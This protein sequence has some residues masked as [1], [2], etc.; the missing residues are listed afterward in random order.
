MIHLRMLLLISL[1]CLYFNPIA[2]AF[3]EGCGKHKNITMDNCKGA[4]C[5]RYCSLNNDYENNNPGACLEFGDFIG[6]KIDDIHQLLKDRDDK[7]KAHTN[8]LRKEAMECASDE[9]SAACAILGKQE[10]IIKLLREWE[11]EKPARKQE[12]SLLRAQQVKI[13]HK[14]CF[15]NT[16]GGE[17]NKKTSCRKKEEALA[18]NYFDFN[19]KA[20][21]KDPAKDIADAI[22]H[23]CSYEGTG[24]GLCILKKAEIYYKEARISV[25]DL[26]LILSGDTGAIIPFVLEKPEQ[27]LKACFDIAKTLYQT[28]C[29]Q[30]SEKDEYRPL[31][32]D[33]VAEIEKGYDSFKAAAGSDFCRD[34]GS[35]IKL[36]NLKRGDHIP[37]SD[38]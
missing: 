38:I 7:S 15:N 3:L 19:E 18:D 34:N 37:E 21:T 27:E 31:C 25:T 4:E 30:F 32:T 24:Y 13:Y 1:Y 6:K 33:R 11:E 9:N 10:D 2:H 22:I 8:R 5:E 23:Y 29:A 16:E 26:S 12:I 20:W 36:P 28:A 14:G 17:E 35:K